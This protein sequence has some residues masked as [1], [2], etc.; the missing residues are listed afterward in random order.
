MSSGGS[1]HTSPNPHFQLQQIQQQQQQQ[2]QQLNGSQTLQQPHQHLTVPT[3]GGHPYIRPSLS[4][5]QQVS[6]PLN[7]QLIQKARTF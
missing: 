2:Q 6:N 7:E 1:S 4:P 3:P 5:P